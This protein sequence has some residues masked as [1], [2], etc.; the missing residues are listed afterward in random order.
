M[1]VDKFIN[2]PPDTFDQNQLEFQNFPIYCRVLGP[3]SPYSQPG[4]NGIR[5]DLN[6]IQFYKA[7]VPMHLAT[8]LKTPIKTVK[9]QKED[10]IFYVGKIALK[11]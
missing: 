2:A 8:Q 7:S 6:S 11:R 9:H 4:V 5:C 10:N 3:P 1:W